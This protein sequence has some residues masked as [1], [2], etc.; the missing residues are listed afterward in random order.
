MLRELERYW[1]SSR[2]N[3]NAIWTADTA[4]LEAIWREQTAELNGALTENDGCKPIKLVWL[5]SGDHTVTDGQATN[6]TAVTCNIDGPVGASNSVEYEIIDYKSVTLKVRDKDCG[7][8]FSRDQKFQHLFTSKQVDLANSLAA[9]VPTKLAAFAGKNLT[10]GELGTYGVSGQTTDQTLLRVA[11][12]NFNLLDMAT[13]VEEIA[14]ANRYSNP[15]L[16]D[17]GNLRY[18]VNNARMQAGTFAGDVGAN[19]ALNNMLPRVYMDGRN[20]RS[21]TLSDSTFLVERGAVAFFTAAYGPV[22]EDVTGNGFAET[23][24]RLPLLG[25]RQANGVGG[26]LPVEVDTTYRRERLP[27]ANGSSLCEDWHIWEMKVWYLCVNNPLLSANDGVTGVTRIKKDAT[28][29]QKGT[30]MQKAL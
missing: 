14:E 9:L 6:K 25:L 13:F 27:I 2:A 11:P 16:F 18:V 1:S 26:T 17:G 10:T 21:A 22:N 24:Y 4:A 23:R 19:N 12:G 29:T 8:H 20:F 7:N 30:P 15:A 5:E 3:E 28:L